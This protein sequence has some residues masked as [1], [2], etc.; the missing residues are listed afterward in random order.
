MGAIA[1][2]PPLLEA[3]GYTGKTGGIKRPGRVKQARAAINIVIENRS[4][5]R[6]FPDK[7]RYV[8]PISMLSASEC[9]LKANNLEIAARTATPDN[10][11][12]Y[13]QAASEWRRRAHEILMEQS[14]PY[15]DSLADASRQQPGR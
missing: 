13:L 5:G 12:L 11:M 8:R 14:D 4:D 15:M 10:R 1:R 7:S 2:G 6:A 9:H 3:A